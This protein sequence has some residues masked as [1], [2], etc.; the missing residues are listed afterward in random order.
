LAKQTI[1]LGDDSAEF[2]SLSEDE[3]KGIVNAS[4]DEKLGAL[5]LPETF[6]ADTFKKDI[7]DEVTNLF[8][9]NK[10][11]EEAFAKKL[12][13]SV[14]DVLGKALKGI[15]NGSTREKQPGA[16]TRFLSS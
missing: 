6:D 13:K 16:L 14:G 10:L 4:L 9:K 2:D 8:E 11:D 12:D 15:G 1:K 3:V 5:E 7:L